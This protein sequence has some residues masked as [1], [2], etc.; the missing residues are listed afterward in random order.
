M[1]GILAVATAEIRQHRIVFWSGLSLGLLPLV[2]HALVHR[3]LL[4][5]VGL[6]EMHPN[7]EGAVW[8]FAIVLSLAVAFGLGAGAV[9]RDLSERRLGFYMARPLPLFQYWAGKL[10]AAWLLAVAAAVLVMLPA[11]LLGSLRWSDT[12]DSLGKALGWS[13]WLKGLAFSVAAASAAASAF[14]T[15]SGLL[16]LDIVMLPLV[17]AATWGAL[18]DAFNAG[19]GEVVMLSAMPWLASLATL[20][21]LAAGAAQVCLGR[22]ELRRGHVLLSAIAWGGLLLFWVGGILAWSR[23]VSTATPA[24]IRL[25]YASVSA[26]GSGDH[27]MIDGISTTWSY[28]YHPGFLIDAR[29]GFLRLGGLQN[30]NGVAWSTGGETFALSAEGPFP[31]ADLP[32]SA[33]PSGPPG[34]EVQSLLIQRLDRPGAPPRRF[35]R[36]EP[37]EAVRAVS[38]SGRRLL[39]ES[40]AGKAIVDAETGR[41]L[42]RLEDLER[43]AGA[44]FLSENRVRA[45]RLRGQPARHIF[46]GLADPARAGRRGQAVIVDWDLGS[47]RASERGTIALA[48]AR[49]APG[50]LAPAPAW[51][52]VLR[53]DDDGLFLHDEAGDVVATLV[54]GWPG[55]GNRGAG[56]LSG[57]RVACVE[58]AHDGLRLRV[59]GP[60]A[61]LASDSRLDGRFPVRIGGEIAP[62]ILALGVSPSAEAGQRATL[63]VDLASGQ[64]VR[65]LAAVWPALRRW[66]WGREPEAGDPVPG[67]FATRLFFADEGLVALDAATDA[68][69]LVVASRRLED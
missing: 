43:W 3:E 31:M 50:R 11:H 53:I 32:P 36:Q 2:L 38:P 23:I 62:G 14:R 42:A 7:A 41:D 69:T 46:P 27:V 9:S 4:R 57:G 58:E 60:D 1:R 5:P 28:H 56:W 21:L 48:G 59:F 25:A 45:L 51:E 63:F 68:R 55:R 65:R 18:A 29:G 67:S 33:R 13:G 39:L 34:F 12:A 8:V 61:R 30:V 37:D 22:L 44:A 49:Q 35:E 24:E 26:P 17:W 16:L 40:S 20:V 19:T 54:D 6:G 47:S 52:R 64:V 66:E 15:G 10:G